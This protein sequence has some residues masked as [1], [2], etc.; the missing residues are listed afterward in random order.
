MRQVQVLPSLP[1]NPRMEGSVLSIGKIRPGRT[2]YHLDAV[3]DG[4]EDYYFSPH[5][6]PGVWLGAAA[7]RLDLAGTVTRDQLL[8]LLEGRHPGTGE[9]LGTTSQVSASRDRL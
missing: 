6:A 8:D 9:R 1:P 4:V 3:A 2:T 5:E 7:T